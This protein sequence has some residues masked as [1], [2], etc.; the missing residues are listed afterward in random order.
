MIGFMFAITMEEAITL[1]VLL[2]IIISLL[3]LVFYK[4][5]QKTLMKKFVGVKKDESRKINSKIIIPAALTGVAVVL[6]RNHLSEA[7]LLIGCVGVGILML[8][9]AIYAYC[10]Y[11]LI[12][13]IESDKSLTSNLYK[14]KR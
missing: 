1:L 10:E 7:F 12:S 13:F 5:V 11:S 2:I 3:G 8:W 14:K 6:M 9:L 4:I